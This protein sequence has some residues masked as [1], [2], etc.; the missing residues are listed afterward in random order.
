MASEKN[1]KQVTFA[2]VTQLELLALRKKCRGNYFIKQGDRSQA[3]MQWGIMNG[4]EAPFNCSAK[5]QYEI[6][7]TWIDNIIMIHITQVEII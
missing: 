2:F 3:Q 6:I 1:E 7:A 5:E 4:E